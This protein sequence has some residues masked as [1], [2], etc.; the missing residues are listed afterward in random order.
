M[1]A[2]HPNETSALGLRNLPFTIHVGGRDSAYN[3]NKIAAQWKQ[4]LANLRKADPAGYPHW[5]KVYPNKGHWLNREDAA[6]IPWMAKY[7][8]NTL[9]TKIVW[10]QDDVSHDRFY[11]LAVTP[12][13]F[14]GRA[15]VIAKRNRQ[16][17]DIQAKDVDRLTIRL[18]DRMLDL[19]KEIV[20][21]SKGKTLFKGHVKRTIAI[22]AKTLTERGDPQD[23]FSSEIKVD[24]RTMKK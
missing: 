22:L 21:T 13:S 8:R 24:L 3:R 6:A 16:K 2:G 5:V 7:S 4:K 18:N 12:G 20:V 11:W 14:R 15:E 19:D 1:M 9:P 10:K 23:V 17:I